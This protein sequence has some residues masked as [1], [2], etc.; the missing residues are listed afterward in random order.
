M[1]SR[2]FLAAAV[3]MAALSPAPL[4]ADDTGV[5]EALHSTFKV[6]NK[7]CFVDHS[8]GGSSSGQLNEKAAKAAAIQ[9][10]AGFT[11]WEYG[12]DW[13]NI[14]KAIRVSM[15]CSQTTSGWGCDLDATPCK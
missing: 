8:H 15:R 4:L 7:R 1:K 3:V 12:T 13:A 10:W 9:S 11:A 6:G 14:R 5:A 2:R